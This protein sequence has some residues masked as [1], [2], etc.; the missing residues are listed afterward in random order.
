MEWSPRKWLSYSFSGGRGADSP[1]LANAVVI[2]GEKLTF[3]AAYIS[4]D[5]NFQ[6]IGTQSTPLVSEPIKDNLYLGLRPLPNFSFSL[7]RQNV[8]SPLTA[9]QPIRYTTS[10]GDYLYRSSG[11][12]SDGL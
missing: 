1:Y 3:K 4:A 6:R 11:L 2:E 9:D 7:S 10:A 5:Q 8:L 12:Q